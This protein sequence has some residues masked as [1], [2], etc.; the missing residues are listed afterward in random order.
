MF[1]PNSSNT[2][3]KPRNKKNN[4]VNGRTDI[5]VSDLDIKPA[6][7]KENLKQIHTTINSQHLS[8]KKRS[9]V[10]NTTPFDIPLSK[11]TLPRHMR[12]K[13]AQ[14]RANKLTL[15]QIYRHTVNLDT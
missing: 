14:L 15:L 13:M 2:R 12:T 3:V 5:I 4:Q 9:K 11:Q 1:Y 10:T 6:E 8:S 7:C